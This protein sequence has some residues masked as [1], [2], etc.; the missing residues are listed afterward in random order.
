MN[1]IG[2]ILCAS[3]NGPLTSTHPPPGGAKTLSSS[4]VNARGISIPPGTKTK[5]PSS[6]NFLDYT[7]L[8]SIR[9]EEKWMLAKLH[10]LPT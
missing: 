10:D 1:R 7:K 8:P 2:N 9:Q 4:F 5:V 6:S 3:W